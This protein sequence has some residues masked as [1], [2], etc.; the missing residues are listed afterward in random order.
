MPI[1]MRRKKVGD[2]I[3]K[4]LRAVFFAIK[5]KRRLYVI[6]AAIRISV[7]KKDKIIL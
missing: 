6:S 1:K 5:F 2:M 4:Y 7:H 3:G